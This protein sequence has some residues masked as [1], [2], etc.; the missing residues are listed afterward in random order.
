MSQ[1]KTH[2]DSDNIST[3]NIDHFNGHVGS[4]FQIKVSDDMTCTMT[5][6]EVRPGKVR[7]K[8]KFPLP[9][10]TTG[11]TREQPFT[12]FFEGEDGAPIAQNSYHCTH[13]TL[14]SGTVFISPHSRTK[15]EDAKHPN[16]HDHSMNVIY[17]A[18]FS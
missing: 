12:L 9:D 1:E 11:E 4:H 5:L 16:C 17:Q 13:A 10:G 14:G 6:V 2:R 15:G 7:P 3:M 18:V 8:Q